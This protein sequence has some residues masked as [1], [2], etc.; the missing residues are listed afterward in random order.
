MIC[1]MIHTIEAA[2]AK[3]LENVKKK[4]K[5]FTKMILSSKKNAF[6]KKKK[7]NAPKVST[8]FIDFNI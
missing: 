2:E 6:Q 8:D 5:P 3:Q 7:L 4:K 1:T